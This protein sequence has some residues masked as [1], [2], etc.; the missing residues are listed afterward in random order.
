M[1]KFR[2]PYESYVAPATNAGDEKKPVF[3]LVNKNGERSLKHVDDIDIQASID[4][5]EAETDLKA[6]LRR[7]SLTGD[8]SILWKGDGSYVYEDVCN[9]ETDLARLIQTTREAALL[10][11]QIAS[12]GKKVSENGQE[13]G[14]LNQDPNAAVAVNIPK[15]KNVEVTNE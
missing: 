6:M 7:Y 11:L 5:Y 10:K 1:S 12:Q 13:E 8:A 4:S 14:Y 2:I 15:T 9:C 3:T